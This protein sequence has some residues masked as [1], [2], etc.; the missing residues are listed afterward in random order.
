MFSLIISNVSNLLG[1]GFNLSFSPKK[2]LKTKLSE[3]YVKKYRER[4]RQCP[5]CFESIE[6]RE[7]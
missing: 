2:V 5:S 4:D 6:T 3:T 7:D 1:P